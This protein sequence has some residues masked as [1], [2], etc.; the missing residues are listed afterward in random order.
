M[1]VPPLALLALQIVF[2]FAALS[3]L[4]S[5][6]SPWL[7]RMERSH[8]LQS[9]LWVHVGRF[10]PL[11]LLAPGQT[12]PS[13]P[14]AV[15]HTIAWGDFLSAVLALV[16]IVAL[17]ARGERGAVWVWIFSAVS[18]VDIVAALATGLGHGVY[19]HSLGVGWYILALYV[20]VV[21]V[22]QWLIGMA[23]LRP[24]G[25]AAREVAA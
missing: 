19:E 18:T 15:L 25:I 22:G 24:R 16:A 7:W 6:V 21:C 14:S 5:T 1:T 3:V 2:A 9:L 12:D 4:A 17:R 11:A 13:I 20:P 23:L 8:A 10:A